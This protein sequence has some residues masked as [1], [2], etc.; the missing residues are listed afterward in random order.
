MSASNEKIIRCVFELLFVAFAT[1]LSD[2]LLA[3][4]EFVSLC[5]KP[6]NSEQ[7]HML[8]VLKISQKTQK[9]NLLYKKIFEGKALI[10]KNN[11]IKD[12]SLLQYAKN[13]KHLDLS[14]N[15]IEDIGPLKYLIGLQV[16]KLDQNQ[17]NSLEPL[18]SANQIRALSVAG[19]KIKNIEDLDFLKGTSVL[20]ISHNPISSGAF[21][22]NLFRLKKLNI[23]HTEIRQVEFAKKLTALEELRISGLNLGSLNALSG[24]SRLKTLAADQN[25]IASVKPLAFIKTLSYLDLSKNQISDI[26]YL[27]K[28]VGMTSLNLSDNYVTV[29]NY[30]A[31]MRYLKGFY[32]ENNNIKSI[33]VLKNLRYIRYLNLSNNRIQDISPLEPNNNLKVVLLSKNQITDLRP[34]LRSKDLVKLHVDFNHI[35]NLRPLVDL[36]QLKELKVNNNPQSFDESTIQ[37]FRSHLP[38]FIFK[39]IIEEKKEDLQTAEDFLAQEEVIYKESD[40]KIYEL[41]RK[42]D[43]VIR[44]FYVVAAIAFIFVHI[45]LFNIFKKIKLNPIHGLI[46][47]YNI[48]VLIRYFKRPDWWFYIMMYPTLSTLLEMVF[49]SNTSIYNVGFSLFTMFNTLIYFVGL[50]FQIVLINGLRKKFWREKKYTYALIFLPFIYIPYLAFSRIRPLKSKRKKKRPTPPK[51]DSV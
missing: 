35:T 11:K 20:D 1:M 28:L 31:N 24:L 51:L 30:L 15:E 4:E 19:N 16:V 2:L 6:E 27:Q 36:P 38:R 49:R 25:S 22:M 26:R 9:C 46:P 42:I 8:K 5:Q 33:D 43:M 48:F 40:Q 47:A 14:N 37:Y 45:C 29:I 12:I 32:A 34:L 13:L 7:A 17:I 41:K 39:D 23:S 18:F 21:L 10:L 50:Y 44:F 3:Q